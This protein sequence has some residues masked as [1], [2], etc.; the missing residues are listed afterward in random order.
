MAMHV[1]TETTR[2]SYRFRQ[3]HISEDGYKLGALYSSPTH[4]FSPYLELTEDELELT[5]AA[6]KMTNNLWE[7]LMHAAPD[8]F[9]QVIS[10]S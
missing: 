1:I 4:S 9:K 10:D 5:A 2:A 3:I 8:K 6:F 7:S